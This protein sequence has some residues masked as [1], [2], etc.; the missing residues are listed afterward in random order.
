MAA[1][2]GKREQNRANKRARITASARALF[3]AKGFEA[4]TMREVARAAGV[5]AGTVFTYAPTKNT[6]LVL[7]FHDE[8]LQV[9]DAGYRA[10][11]KQREAG[12]VEQALIYFNAMIEY[13][14]QDLPLA[15]ALMREL[16]CLTDDDQRALVNQLM[17]TLYAN[18]GALV[19]AARE[20][21]E[22][23]RTCAVRSATR[24][25][26]AIYYLHLNTYL[27]GAIERAFFDRVLRADLELL[28][29]GLKH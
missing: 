21:G 13:H 3:S 15:R 28:T 23:S 8:M 29:V 17:S 25:V 16:G 22:L 6:L 5:A 1:Q 19:E 4:T 18:L 24:S 7:V 2:A 27:N 12:F 20:A 11:S 10:A 9:I 26:F 14:E